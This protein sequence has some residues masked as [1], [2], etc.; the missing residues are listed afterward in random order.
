MKLKKFSKDEIIFN[1]IEA[2]PQ[3]TFTFAGGNTYLNNVSSSNSNVPNGS[4]SAFDLS[5]NRTGT[6]RIF[7][8]LNKDADRAAF[9]TT[10][11]SSYDS[12]LPGAEFKTFLAL[13]SSV[14]VELGT[15]L[16]HTKA[17]ENVINHYRRL[18]K[19]FDYSTFF[20]N[21]Q[22]KLISIPSIFYGSSLNKG[23]IELDYY[24]TGSLVAKAIDKNNNGELIQVSGSA[25]GTLDAVV[26]VALYNEGFI[27][28][29]S[30]ASLS[31]A[32][33]GYT[34][35]NATGSWLDFADTGNGVLSSSFEM[36]FKGK[37]FTPTV[38]MFAHAPDGKYNF[39]SNPTFLSGGNSNNTTTGSYSFFEAS[40]S[41][42][43]IATS[44][45]GNFTA[46]FKKTTFISKVMIYDDNQ[47][48]LGV[49]HL[50]EPIKKTE[51]DAY[52]FKLKL[53]I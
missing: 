26:G 51:E 48:L 27:A 17:L 15:D 30:S 29:F 3:V 6:D 12:A 37:T 7:Q 4:L 23:D 19:F 20:D 11:T 18:S 36:K 45:L 41:I 42:K 47:R 43:N 13:T 53:D 52:T 35:A 21:K 28:L 39:S 40:S 16:A 49:A 44:S 46:P 1:T 22:I 32:F 10:T 38:T 14:Q 2:H 50:A 31:G 9:K 8:F 5:V 24:Y 33:D 34:S 25:T